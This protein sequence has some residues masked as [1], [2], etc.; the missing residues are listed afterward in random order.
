MNILVRQ[1]REE[2]LV[3]FRPIG[4]KKSFSALGIVVPKIAGFVRYATN[5]HDRNFNL[6]LEYN[7]F[8][9]LRLLSRQDVL[10]NVHLGMQY[11]KTEE[12]AAPQ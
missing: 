7:F 9:L 8:V 6:L 4:R 3:S 5:V 11:G 12:R 2:L 10:D 1:A